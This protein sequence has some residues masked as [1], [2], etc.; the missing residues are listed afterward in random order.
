MS[1]S[2]WVDWRKPV[3]DLEEPG[4]VTERADRSSPGEWDEDLGRFG[5]DPWNLPGFGESGPGC[6]EWYPEAV[7]DTCGHLELGTHNCGRRSCP[8]CWGIWAKKSAVRAA[9][10]IQSFRYTQP[11]DYHRQ[12]AHAIVS[13]SEGE[14]RT[15]REFWEG[16]KRAAEIAERKG[17]RGFAIV[18]HPWR[19]TDRAKQRYREADPDY[20]IWVWLRRDVG[21]LEDLIYWSPHYHV[22]GATTA[23]MEPAKDSD[24]WVY[25]FER[26]L[27]SF[28]GIR[29]KE[30]HEDVYGVF[31]Y[32]L[33]HTGFPEGSTKQVT[34]W[35]GDLANSVFVEEASEA[36]QI[37]K[38]SE[39]VRSALK[40]EIEEVAGEK[41]EESEG[42]SEGDEEEECVLE[43][44]D[45]LLINVFDVPRYLE[46]GDVPSEIA[47]RM[48]TAYEWRV[49]DIHPPPGLKN[50]QTEA[51][52]RE[53]FG[54][55][56]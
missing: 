4:W 26:S 3:P 46:G 39:G 37:E 36:W 50:P 44:C 1:A 49:G 35:Y 32:L 15:E 54:Y 42:G 33:S 22:I 40:R 31:R 48:V 38:P 56:L 47:Q 12:V 21:N 29:D 2:E 10:R 17:F 5:V 41:L 20:G 27:R 9:V 34:T 51:D 53:A 52:A 6:G 55:L 24:G 8:D 28:E 13:P 45:G 11:P 18:P 30:S 43:D 25:R 23:N 19:P 7:C 14:I 16:R